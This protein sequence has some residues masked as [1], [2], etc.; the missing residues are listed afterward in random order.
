MSEKK[1]DP[2]DRM[3]YTDRD[4]V[5]GGIKII[6]FDPTNPEEVKKLRDLQIKYGILK[7]DSLQEDPDG[8]L[9]DE[10]KLS[11]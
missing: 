2:L 1:I 7:S 11:K 3:G 10:E 8:S 9:Q 5:G 4:F 6:P